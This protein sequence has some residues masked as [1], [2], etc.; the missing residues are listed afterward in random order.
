[1]TASALL[2]P[3]EKNLNNLFI[4]SVNSFHLA[5]KYTGLSTSVHYK[6]IDSH[7]YLLHSCSHPQQVK[8]AIPFSQFLRLRRLCSD[9]T[10]FNNKCENMRQ[11]FKKRGNPDS[12]VTMHRQT[13][14][15]NKSTKRPHYKL[16]RTKKSTEFHSPL[17]TIHKT[18]Q[19]KCHSQN[20]LRN[21]PETKHIFSLHRSCHSNATKT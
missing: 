13:P 1:M 3:A 6:P 9:D 15:P 5:L 7:D 21:D 11:F 10:D 4:H 8:D 20:L 12:A 17:P 2:H 18:L 19:S 14:R 16:H